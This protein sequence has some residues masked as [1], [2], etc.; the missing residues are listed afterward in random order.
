MLKIMGLTF[1][2][3]PFLIISSDPPGMEPGR[4]VY[5]DNSRSREIGGGGVKIGG[6][7][8]MR[9]KPV[10]DPRCYNPEA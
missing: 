6:G 8:A 5:R 9:S 1:W 10:F 4:C 2:F 3:H 7:G